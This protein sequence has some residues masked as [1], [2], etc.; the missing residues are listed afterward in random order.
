MFHA[1]DHDTAEEESYNNDFL[2]QYCYVETYICYLLF[3]PFPPH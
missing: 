1:V 2:L 3:L